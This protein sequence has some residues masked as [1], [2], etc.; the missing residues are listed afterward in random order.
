LAD[1]DELT[2][3]QALALQRY[4]IAARNRRRFK[5]L[6]LASRSTLRLIGAFSEGLD[7][8]RAHDAEGLALLTQRSVPAYRRLSK[9]D[10]AIAYAHRMALRTLR[11]TGVR[12]PR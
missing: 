6:R 3:A 11:A 7:P 8:G 1:F 9:I 12:T 10:R 5:L 2:E 4:E